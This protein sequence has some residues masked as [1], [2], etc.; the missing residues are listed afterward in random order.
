MTTLPVFGALLEATTAILV[1]KIINKHKVNFKNYIVYIFAS[2]VLV[3]LPFIFFFWKVDPIA[4]RLPYLLLF[5]SMVVVA[6][7]ANY[8]IFYSLKKEDLSEITPIRLTTPLFTIL[9][10]FILS[11]FFSSY[12]GEG[13]YKILIIAL[14]AS[15]ALI[16]AHVEKDHFNFN[17]YSMAALVGSFLFAIDLVMIKP[18]LLYYNPLTLYFIRAI[19]IFTI[20]WIIFHPKLGSIA[21]KTR[22]LV[23][24]ASIAAVFMR[25]ILYYGFQTLG[26]VFTTTIFI[27]APVLTYIFPAIFLKE[28]ITK[29]QIF[30]SIVI[31][32]CVVAAILIGN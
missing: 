28:E 22:L 6:I 13:N 10:A 8:F 2:I 5:F 9:L 29:K 31:I 1:K 18:L 3:S 4:L 21:N 19:F 17:K 14:I 30:S 12:V 26:I 32:G 27:L 20:T 23:L 11:F 7:F 24:F 25:I 15:L 16:I